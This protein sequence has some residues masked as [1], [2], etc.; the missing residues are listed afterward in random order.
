MSAVSFSVIEYSDYTPTVCLGMEL[1]PERQ[2]E[3]AGCFEHDNNKLSGSI[4]EGGFLD[5]L[6]NCLLSGRAVLH[7]LN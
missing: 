3:L 7:V 5:Q 1:V 2:R 6:S 4:K